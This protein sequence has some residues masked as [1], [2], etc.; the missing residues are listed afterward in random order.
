[1]QRTATPCTP[2]RFRPAPPFSQS[3][4]IAPKTRGRH[5]LPSWI[6]TSRGPGGGIG[7]HRRLK[8]SRLH[9]RA[10]SSPAPGTNFNKAIFF[11]RFSG[12][13]LQRLKRPDYSGPSGAQ[14]K[15]DTQSFSDPFRPAPG[16]ACPMRRT[17]AL[18][19]TP[20]FPLGPMASMVV[21]KI[22]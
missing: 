17:N 20:R 12:F 4:V 22:Q 16:R 8:I 2:V 7:R 21:P 18:G 11:F 19:T 3:G 6:N 13:A 1:M 14:R 9:G 5:E 10:G 15:N